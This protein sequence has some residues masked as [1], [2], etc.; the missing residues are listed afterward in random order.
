MNEIK[1]KSNIIR[2]RYTIEKYLIINSLIAVVS[3]FIIGERVFIGYDPPLIIVE[4]I[5]IPVNIEIILLPVLVVIYIII[6]IRCWIKKIFI[7]I[8]IKRVIG[9]IIVLVSFFYF[10]WFSN[11]MRGSGFLSD[12]EKYQEGNKYYIRHGEMNLRCTKNEFNLILEDKTY[13]IQYSSNKL[14]SNK[15]ILEVIEIHDYRNE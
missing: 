15:G 7:K 2:V 10:I 8:T 4:L 11:G 14:L 12:I 9:F 5:A 6:V 3:L 1:D 13:Y